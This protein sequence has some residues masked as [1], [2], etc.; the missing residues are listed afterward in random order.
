MERVLAPVLTDRSVE[1]MRL[2]LGGAGTITL[3]DLSQVFARISSMSP[4]PGQRRREKREKN[5]LGCG[6]IEVSNDGSRQG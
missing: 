2:G 4:L 5:G 6:K 3:R 1:R